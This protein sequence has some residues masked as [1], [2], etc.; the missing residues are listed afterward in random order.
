MVFQAWVLS[1]DVPSVFLGQQVCEKV[2][3]TSCVNVYI[4]YL[5]C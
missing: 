3:L 4:M 2:D 1:V 5:K